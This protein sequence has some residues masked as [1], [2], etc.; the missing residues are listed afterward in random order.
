MTNTEIY[1][2]LTS[3][4]RAELRQ[5]ELQLSA[6]SMPSDFVGWDSTAMVGIILSI[7]DEFGFEMSP[8]DLRQARSVADLADIIARHWRSQDGQ[9]AGTA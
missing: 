4:V 6:R 1:D 2:R 5:P 8:Q 3:V 7:E 9:S